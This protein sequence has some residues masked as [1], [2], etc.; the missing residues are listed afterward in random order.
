MLNNQLKVMKSYF[1]GY[2]NAQFFNT[3]QKPE[4]SFKEI[5]DYM[6]K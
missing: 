3:E 6:I 5:L 2:S 1:A 4:D